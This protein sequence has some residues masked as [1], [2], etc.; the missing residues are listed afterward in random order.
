MMYHLERFS[1][2]QW[3]EVLFLFAPVIL[4]FIIAAGLVAVSPYLVILVAS[5]FYSINKHF[6]MVLCHIY[7]HNFY[8]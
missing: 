3:A 4:G 6:F 5:L 1:P 2:K 7:D 8:K